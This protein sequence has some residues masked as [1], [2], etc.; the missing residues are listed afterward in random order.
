ML[1][2]GSEDIDSKQSGFHHYDASQLLE[3]DVIGRAVWSLPT[4]SDLSLSA[5]LNDDEDRDLLFDDDGLHFNE[6]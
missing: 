5:R 6:M 4:T 2:L 3:L 1:G